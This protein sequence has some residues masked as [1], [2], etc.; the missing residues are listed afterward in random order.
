MCRAHH[1]ATPAIPA[2]PT[3]EDARLKLFISAPTTDFLNSDLFPASL[4][5]LRNSL[6]EH[7]CYFI[8]F[9]HHA[10]GSTLSSISEVSEL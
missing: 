5:V 6:I 1:D 2:P 10:S 9:Q 3:Q 4:S 8:K 7:E